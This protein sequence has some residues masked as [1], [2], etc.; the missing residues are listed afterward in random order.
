M[1]VA[2]LELHRL[3]TWARVISPDSRG[4]GDER[5]QTTSSF[6]IV[7]PETL[8]ISELVYGFVAVRILGT[9]PL[10]CR[11][12][13]K[14]TV[15][16]ESHLI[17][18]VNDR[19][20]LAQVQF[21]AL[22]QHEAEWPAWSRDVAVGVRFEAAVHVEYQWKCV[23]VVGRIDNPENNGRG[24]SAVGSQR[25]WTKPRQLSRSPILVQMEPVVYWIGGYE[26]LV[27]F[28]PSRVP[29]IPV[30]RLSL[31]TTWRLAS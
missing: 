20:R 17:Q 14:L 4:T 27:G 9:G 10:A 22:R 16:E 2:S 28:Q 3:S 26:P 12:I 29:F 15:Q 7:N 6:R 5:F 1:Q 19:V 30:Q 23:R 8:L 31:R 25:D 13:D 11:L 24:D 21:S 18:E